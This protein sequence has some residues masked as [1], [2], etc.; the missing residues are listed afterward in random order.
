MNPL[1]GFDYVRLSLLVFVGLF[2]L[3]DAVLLVARP[4]WMWSYASHTN[5]WLRALIITT[6][7]GFALHL[8]YEW[9]PR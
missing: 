8:A 4:E 9:W 7:V 2:I 3:S 6:W 1:D 5:Y